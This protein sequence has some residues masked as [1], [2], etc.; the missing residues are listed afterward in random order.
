MFYCVR[1][2]THLIL[3]EDKTSGEIVTILYPDYHENI[4][5]KIA[6]ETLVHAENLAYNQ[7]ITKENFGQKVLTA[8][9]AEFLSKRGKCH[10]VNL[11]SHLI[12]WHSNIKISRSGIQTICDALDL[13]SQNL[14][15]L[16]NVKVTNTDTFA[17]LTITKQQITAFKEYS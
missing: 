2:H 17:N 8:A 14:T 15:Y 4:S 11:G 3:V 1:S 16:S 5:W 13:T 12:E 6:P 9:M 10:M 7:V